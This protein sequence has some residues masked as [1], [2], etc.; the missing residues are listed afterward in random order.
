MNVPRFWFR[1]ARVPQVCRDARFLKVYD[2][3]ISCVVLALKL[4]RWRRSR[5]PY[6]PIPE[7][8]EP[9]PLPIPILVLKKRHRLDDPSCM[10]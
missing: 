2:D 9:I 1:L 6:V 10:L 7:L 5:L 4:L 3:I 8:P